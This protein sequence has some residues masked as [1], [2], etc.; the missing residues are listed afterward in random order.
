MSS[1]HGNVIQNI[2]ELH[3]EMAIDDAL[4]QGDLATAKRLAFQ[5][6]PVE[7]AAPPGEKKKPAPKISNP[8]LRSRAK[9]YFA[10][11]ELE[12]ASADAEQAFLAVNSRAGWL[13]LRTLELDETEKLKAAIL[14][15]SEPRQSE[16]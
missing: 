14:K 7:E 8:H 5:F 11:G 6:A 15:A 4:A 1:Q 9:V 10:M 13:S 16:P 2:V 3:D 12:A